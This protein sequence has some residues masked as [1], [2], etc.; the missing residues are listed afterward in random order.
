MKK[1]IEQR[2]IKWK[3]NHNL[4]ELGKCFTY[5]GH[6]YRLI[7]SHMS[8]EFRDM[9]NL[10][11]IKNAVNDRLLVPAK[12]VDDIELEG[13]EGCL[14][15]EHPMLP[16]VTESNEWSV[17]MLGKAMQMILKLELTL[18]SAGY[19][20]ADPHCNNVAFDGTV[21]MYLDWGSIRPLSAIGFIALREIRERW[22]YPYLFWK[23]SG[24]EYDAYRDFFYIHTRMSTERFEILTNGNPVSALC[25]EIVATCEY[26]LYDNTVAGGKFTE[27]VFGMIRSLRHIDENKTRQ[28]MCKKVRGYLGIVESDIADITRKSSSFPAKGESGNDVTDWIAQYLINAG[29][30]RIVY[31]TDRETYE[32]VNVVSDSEMAWMIC[33]NDT[34]LIDDMVADS[35]TRVNYS[36]T[37]VFERRKISDE[38]RLHRYMAD[39]LILTRPVNLYLEKDCITIVF[40]MNTIR[41]Y[42]CGSV[43][44]R[45]VGA[46]N[47]AQDIMDKIICMDGIEIEATKSFENETVVVVGL[48]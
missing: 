29:I 43:V 38:A 2:D 11:A 30:H 37:D 5:N 44:L 8:N 36:V 14:I 18:L 17:L 13:Y 26:R 19:G 20:L 48:E 25:H 12:I 33:A 3:T 40:L 46:S 28:Y 10:D 21:P 35:D 31:W 16:Y 23:K 27:T 1:R 34:L 24:L 22:M 15:V 39:A 42:S 9:L 45:I 6:F 47:A 32:Y 41:T 7:Y 4:D